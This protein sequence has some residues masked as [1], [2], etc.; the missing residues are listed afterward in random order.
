MILK[1]D[2]YNLGATTLEGLFLRLARQMLIIQKTSSLNPNEI[3]DLVA[4]DTD[5]TEKR[6]S[7]SIANVTG[8]FKLDSLDIITPFTDTLTPAA[9]GLA[10]PWNATNHLE[11]LIKIGIKICNL[12]RNSEINKNS[13]FIFDYSIASKGDV[14]EPHFDISLNA[15]DIPLI[16]TLNGQTSISE[17]DSWLTGEVG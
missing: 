17:S 8:N 15:T 9:E 2:H 1:T 7:V 16:I 12:E 6:A 14:V 11:A 4:V 13:K 3:T 10:P 5:E